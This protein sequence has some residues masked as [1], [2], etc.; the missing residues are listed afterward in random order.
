[1]CSLTSGSVEELKRLVCYGVVAQLNFLV[2]AKVQI[3]TV[4]FILVLLWVFFFP[5]SGEFIKISHAASLFN[6]SCSHTTAVLISREINKVSL[7]D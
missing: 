7:L 5:K 1:M 4:L 2:L 3:V 6:D